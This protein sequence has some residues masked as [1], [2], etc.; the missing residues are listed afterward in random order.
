VLVAVVVIDVAVHVRV[1]DPVEV[2][3]L[4]GVRVVGIVVVRVT[5]LIHERALPC[6]GVG[7]I[8]RSWERGEQ[9]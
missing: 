6:G 3:V 4:V 1:L 5:L 2:P 9:S 7:N 8:S